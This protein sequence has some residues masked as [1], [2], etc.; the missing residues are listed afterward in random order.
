[1]P[2]DTLPTYGHA[3]SSNRSSNGGE[4]LLIQYKSH[5][6]PAVTIKISSVKPT[7]HLSDGD[8]WV[9]RRSERI[10]AGYLYLG[11][12]LSSETKIEWSEKQ[13][14]AFRKEFEVLME[15]LD[16]DPWVSYEVIKQLR[17]TR[18]DQWFVE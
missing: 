10:N 18:W 4:V 7:K 1:M 17:S 14:E 2:I 13:M 3:F 16:D 11:F 15:C 8:G 5:N 12:K 6:N 9:F